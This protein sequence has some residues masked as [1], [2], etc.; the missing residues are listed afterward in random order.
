MQWLK[1]EF[2]LGVTRDDSRFVLQ[3]SG[4]LH[5]PIVIPN[6]Q[7][8]LY[9]VL[10]FLVISF[11]SIYIFMCIHLFMIGLFNVTAGNIA[12]TSWLATQLSVMI[13]PE[14]RSISSNITAVQGGQIPLDVVADGRPTPIVTWTKDGEPVSAN[15]SFP[16]FQKKKSSAYNCRM[17]FH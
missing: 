8:T 14:I 13:P 9:C 6:D 5:I 3:E 11:K 17:L 10:Y 16:L 1:N 12:G 2:P 15:L 7:G 4:S